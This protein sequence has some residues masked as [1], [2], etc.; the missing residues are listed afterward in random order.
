MYL[1]ASNSVV[2][3]ERAYD[4]YYKHLSSPCVQVAM[5]EFL[6][7]SDQ[8]RIDEFVATPEYEREPEMLLPNDSD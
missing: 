2:R 7:D 8:N 1:R 6:S 3:R 4:L 5:T